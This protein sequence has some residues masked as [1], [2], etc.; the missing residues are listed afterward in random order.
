VSAQADS[1]TEPAIRGFVDGVSGTQIDGWAFETAHP[2]ERVVVELRLDGQ[3]VA[4]TVAD[5]H[6][7]DLIRAGIGDAFHGFRFQLR[8]AWA[9][10]R[11]DLQVVAR[12]LDGTEAVL[13][14][15]RRGSPPAAVPEAPN[16]QVMK[17]IEQLVA[18]QRT[19]EGRLHDLAA[20]LPDP[21]LP[22]PSLPVAVQPA[23]PPSLPA[24]SAEAEARMAALEAWVAR[25]DERLAGLQVGPAAAARADAG[26]DTWQVVLMALLALVGFGAL[27]AF[28]LVLAL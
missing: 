2:T 27:A 15:F 24:E 16:P 8:P 18:N 4:T 23:A 21:S 17:A 25:L 6:R 1:R 9:E 3:R 26:L 22:D 28:A 12:G 5:R 20:R 11:S 13:P 19:L 14:L 10:R 7:A